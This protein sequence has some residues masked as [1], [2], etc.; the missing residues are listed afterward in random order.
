[1]DTDKNPTQP[2]IEVTPEMIEAGAETLRG[3][4]NWDFGPND[5]SYL[6]ELILRS[7]LKVPRS[8][9]SKAPISASASMADHFSPEC[10]AWLD[11]VRAEERK[12]F[13]PML[14]AMLLEAQNLRLS[15]GRFGRSLRDSVD[16]IN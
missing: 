10:R 8:E 2:E 3:L 5:S 1:M 11:K 7:A 9:T 15:K 12:R 4:Y 6:A 13:G 14:D 16:G